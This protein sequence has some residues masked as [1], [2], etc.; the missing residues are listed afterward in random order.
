[1]AMK[2]A[3]VIRNLQGAL[4]DP[5][6][7]HVPAFTL[8]SAKKSL[9]ECL[10]IFEEMQQKKGEDNPADLSVDVLDVA[11]LSRV[12]MVD[13]KAVNAGLSLVKKLRNRGNE[14]V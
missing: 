3:P 8:V 9:A 5:E 1:M 12:G 13:A 10:V 7:Q 14:E 4:A 2:L 11:E 6:I